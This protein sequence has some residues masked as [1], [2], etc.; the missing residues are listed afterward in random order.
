MI[1]LILNLTSVL[2]SDL[3]LAPTVT[4]LVGGGP[5]EFTRAEYQTTVKEN[6]RVPNLL[7][8]SARVTPQGQYMK[9]QP[10]LPCQVLVILYPYFV[11]LYDTFLRRGNDNVI[12]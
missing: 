7:Q 10:K 5:V 2:T 1:L 11:S 4:K 12:C 6:T 8:L 9:P 3:C